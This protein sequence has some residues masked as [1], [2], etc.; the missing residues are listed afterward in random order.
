M[1]ACLALVRAF[2]KAQPWLGKGGVFVSFV[3][4]AIA[5]LLFALYLWDMIAHLT[6]SSPYKRQSFENLMTGHYAWM[7]WA[8]IVCS[9]IPQLLWFRRI[10]QNAFALLAIAIASAPPFLIQIIV[11]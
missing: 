5:T 4:M 7:Y 11:R 6:S 2:L 8:R 9:L 3:F 10:R 1:I